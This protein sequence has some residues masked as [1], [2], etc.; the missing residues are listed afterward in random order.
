MSSTVDDDVVAALRATV[1]GRVD[2]DV[3][4]G[5][6]TTLKVGGPARAL[7]TADTPA[8][9]AAVAGVCRDLQVPWL[10]LGRGSNLLVAD[11][12]WR[13]VVVTLGAAFRG[14]HI[15]GT[16]VAAGGA[17]PMP[18][19][20]H[21]VARA[22]LAGLAYGVAIP[23][24]VGGAVRMNAGA[25][26]QETREVLEWA[27]VARLGRGGATERLT[28]ADLDMRYR[29]TRLPS[30]AV[31]VRAGFALRP[32]SDAALAAD[33]ADMQQ[34]RRTHQPLGEPS[35]GSVFR[36]PPDDSA[37]R[38]IDA[39]GLKGHRHGGARISDKHAN[40]ITAGADATA[41]DVHA[42]IRLAQREVARL[43]GVRLE[44]EVVIVGFGDD[45]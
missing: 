1:P 8:D 9:L 15:D 4:L 22:G 25:H 27:D 11:D 21:T 40:F 18:A 30:D 3:P 24:T 20:A 41:A 6:K 32:A 34:W 29:H 31:V 39:A 2:A 12:G 13:G 38:L 26:G 44:P 16:R 7:V 23:G 35:C 37:G 33:M 36:N 17:E 42:L 45:S 19:L 28:V 14:V 43:H 5:P 10:I